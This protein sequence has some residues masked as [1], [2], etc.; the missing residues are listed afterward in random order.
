[1]VSVRE[2]RGVVYVNFSRRRWAEDFTV[3]VLKRNE[4]KFTSS[5]LELRKLA[6]RD[7]RIRGVIEAR[8]GPWIEAAHLSQIEIAETK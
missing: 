1:M 3:T 8:G 2:S 6:G 5:G 4:R 7:V